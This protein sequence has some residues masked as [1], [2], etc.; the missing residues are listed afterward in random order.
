MRV[1]KKVHALLSSLPKGVQVD[2]PIFDEHT[3]NPVARN[4][5]QLQETQKPST[6]PS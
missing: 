2:T 6:A 3:G 1:Y 5:C 4:L